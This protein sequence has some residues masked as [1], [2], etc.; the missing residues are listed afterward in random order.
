MLSGLPATGSRF[1]AGV[2][3]KPASGDDWENTQRM[4]FLPAT[5]V[6]LVLRLL[7][8][9]LAFC[10]PRGWGAAAAVDRSR[11]PTAGPE[12]A[13]AFPDYSEKTLPNGL[14]VFVVESRRQPTVTFRLLVKRGD[15]GDG[16]KP[17][18]ADATAALLNKGT[19]SRDAERFAEETDRLGASVEAASGADALSVSAG[20]L[21]KFLPQILDLFADAAL[22]PAFPEGELAKHQTRELSRLAQ[23]RQQPAALAA[24]LRGKLLYGDRHP[25]GAFET[26]QSVRALTRGDLAAFHRANFLPN[27]ATLA[28]VGDVRAGE[29]I[30]QV[31]RAFADWQPGELPKLDLPPL[32]SVPERTTVHL[33]DRPG[34]VQSAVL[35]S[36]PGM[37][38]GNPDLPELGVVNS[39]L[40]GGFS[41]RL[42]QNLRERHGYTYAASSSLS[43]LGQAGLFSVSSEVRNEVT[44]PAVGEILHE[45]R[46]LREEPIPE[47]ELGMQRSYLAG[48][49]LLSLESPARTAERVQEMDLY[50]LPGDYYKTYARR[51][52]GV[53]VERAREL[54][55]RYVPGEAV[56]VVVVG[57][58]GQI[59]A[60]LEKLGPVVVYDL[61]L[62]A[63]G[64]GSKA[65]GT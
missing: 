38:R 44:G 40:G 33:V 15:I 1:A 5:R 3:R 51:V 21:L 10:P 61:D 17:G 14:K 36:A 55:R 13:G 65:G 57:E 62:K 43:A 22:R 50:G 48:N 49:Y 8:A 7:P 60:E 4:R 37:P 30:G 16:D 56:T 28:I 59:K 42:F 23:E 31:E 46:R 53:T 2:A 52:G 19:T 32:P 45:L 20:G 39:V 41:G 24:K 27:A 9:L 63:K 58:A 11:P 26:E 35:V 34:S 12:P 29:V 6:R 25:Y 47:G 64:E 18:L 54:A